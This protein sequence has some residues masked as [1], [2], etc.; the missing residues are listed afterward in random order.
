MVEGIGRDIGECPLATTFPDRIRAVQQALTTFAKPAAAADLASQ[1]KR[2]RNL[3]ATISELLKTLV[4]VGQ[5]RRTK[6]GKFAG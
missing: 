6:G 4:A 2:V 5:A 1:T 3:E